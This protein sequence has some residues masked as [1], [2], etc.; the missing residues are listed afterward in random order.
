MHVFQERAFAAHDDERFALEP[1]AHLREGM[2]EVL[3]IEFSEP[4]QSSSY[5]LN[6]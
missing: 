3:L 1:I 5:G 2:P 6:F 4:V